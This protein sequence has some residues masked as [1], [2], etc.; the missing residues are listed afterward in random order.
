MAI[1]LRD[2]MRGGLFNAGQVAGFGVS[3]ALGFATP[4]AL[5]GVGAAGRIAQ[6]Y[7]IAQAGIGSY[8]TTT[9]ILDGKMD[10][11]NPLSYLEV[12]GSYAPLI[13]FG[14]KI[15]GK[16]SLPICR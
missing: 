8:N 3:L 9:K 15:A 2:S 4:N 12:A 16:A 1:R 14:A 6:G 10:W 11:S 5:V 7:T 13:G